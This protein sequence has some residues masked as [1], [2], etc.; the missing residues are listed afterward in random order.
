MA[1][2]AR[3][4]SVA[5]TLTVPVFWTIKYSHVFVKRVTYHPIVKLERNAFANSLKFTTRP[6]KALTVFSA[7]K[8]RRRKGRA[9]CFK[10]KDEKNK[11]SLHSPSFSFRVCI[12]RRN[13]RNCCGFYDPSNFVFIRWPPTLNEFAYRARETMLNGKSN[14]R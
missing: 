6:E 7:R 1:E 10:R 12:P 3:P 11:I 5:H 9:L 2:I 4:D 14:V 13:S 8:E